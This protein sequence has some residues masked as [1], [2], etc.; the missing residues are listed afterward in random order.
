MNILVKDN[1]TISDIQKEFETTFQ[2][3]KLMFFKKPHSTAEGSAKKDLLNGS[4]KLTN[5]RHKNGKISFD[6][7]ITVSELEELFKDHFGLNVQVFRKS[8]SSWIETTVTN[9]WTLKKQNDQGKELS[10]L[11]F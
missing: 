11:S 5:I 9:S 1:L 2:Y 8:G 3:L 7:N 6:E 10:E 4:L